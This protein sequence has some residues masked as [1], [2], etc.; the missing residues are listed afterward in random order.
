MANKTNT[1]THLTM[2]SEWIWWRQP[3]SIF[4]SS[5]VGREKWLAWRTEMHARD[6]GLRMCVTNAA[7][8]KHARTSRSYL[9]YTIKDSDANWWSGVQMIFVVFS[10]RWMRKAT[11]RTQPNAD[12]YIKNMDSVM[13]CRIET[14]TYGQMQYFGLTS[15]KMFNIKY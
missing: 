7:K 11:T 15:V 3:I 4:W 5:N 12:N 1:H 13:G 6:R 8:E 2:Y 10:F 14:R 9:L